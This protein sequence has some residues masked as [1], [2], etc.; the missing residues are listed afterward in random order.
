MAGLLLAGLPIAAQIRFGETSS[1]LS[2]T[3]SSGYSADFGNMTSSDHGFTVGGDGILTGSYYKPSFL[4]YTGSFFLN[5]SRAN[6][7]YQSIS[8]ASGYNLSTNLFG[9]SHYPGSITYSRLYDSEGSYAVPGLPNFVTHGNNDTFGV[10]WSERLPGVPSFSATYQMGSGSYSTYGT[11]EE[12][13]NA[14][15]SLNLHSSYQMAGF[16]MSGYYTDGGTRARIPEILTGGQAEETHSG[17]TAY[18]FSLSHRLPRS[19]SASTNISRSEYST[20]FEDFNLSGTIDIINSSASIQ[21]TRK[22]S[23][24]GAANYSDNLSGQLTE[25]VVAAGGAVEGVNS[26][27]GSSSLDLEAAAS[28]SV[29]KDLQTDV[30]VERRSQ[31][32]L[33]RN[34]SALTYGGGAYYM[35]KM[36]DGYFSASVNATGNESGTDSANDL[37]FTA[38]T[39]YS[40]DIR[41]WRVDGTANYA[42]NVQT[43]LITYLNSFYSYS[44]S[45]GKRWGKLSFSMGAGGS[46]TALT[47]QPGTSSGGQDYNASLGYNPWFTLTGTYAKSYGQALETG[48]GLVG[49]PVPTP[50]LPSDLVSLYGGDGYSFGLGSAPIRGLT[51]SAGYSKSIS[52][53][54]TSG[55]SSTN[56]NDEYNAT[57]QYHVRKFQLFSGYSRLDQGFSGSGTVPESVSSYYIGVTRWFKFF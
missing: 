42:Q 38:T 10:G 54:S 55:L 46:R 27:V 52:S 40:T 50:I 37:G 4:S 26:S 43:L 2:G 9:G 36:L 20:E 33:G 32:Y 13:N 31:S 47:D 21:P 12:G 57:I 6:S 28:Y 34:Y 8:N 17:N 51:L 49:V 39:S 7:N 23:L 1:N 56:E 30:H 44:G 41:G 19:G 45:A 14:F 5:Q 24:S 18:G 16:R 11:N 29:E 15:H 3:V 25:A 22:L 35:R 48:A 53:V